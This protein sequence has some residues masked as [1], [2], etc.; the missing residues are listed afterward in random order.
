MISNDG[1][2]CFLNKLY[3]NNKINYNDMFHENKNLL[4][5]LITLYDIHLDINVPIYET[6]MEFCIDVLNKQ[7]LFPNDI[8]N[9]CYFCS[10]MTHFTTLTGSFEL[11]YEK[12]LNKLIEKLNENIDELC[13]YDIVEL[14][15]HLAYI[16]KHNTMIRKNKIFTFII[17]RLIEHANCSPSLKFNKNVQFYIKSLNDSLT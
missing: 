3:H 14:Y 10:H 17:N 15:E 8:V 12:F 2:I 4:L 5:K 7:K 11:L 13:L 16:S 9:L 6:Q 1:C